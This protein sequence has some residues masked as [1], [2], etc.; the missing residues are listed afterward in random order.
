[1]KKKIFIIIGVLFTVT[2][3]FSQDFIK[4]ISNIEKVKVLD[5]HGDLNIEGVI[6]DKIQISVESQKGLPVDA[7]MARPPYFKAE[8]TGIGLSF[9]IVEGIVIIS[10][11]NQT[12]QFTNYDLK[13]PKTSQ[14][15]IKTEHLDENIEITDTKNTEIFNKINV[16]NIEAEIIIEV[17]ASKIDLSDITGPLAMA[18]FAGNCQIVFSGLN[19]DNPS[20]IE[21]FS[22]RIEVAIPENSGFNIQLGSELG[23]IYSEFDIDVKESVPSKSKNANFLNIDFKGLL[24]DEINYTGEEY[25]ASKLSGL[26]INGG[27]NLSI[28]IF[29]GNINLKKK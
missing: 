17:F 22:G 16:K 26:V 20:V 7:S 13:I 9:E 4:E 19:Q 10:P 25:T 11:A 29:A 23:E 6:D 28:N 12:A 1:M 15:E 18:V 2:N 27:I 5:I 24:S 8:N 3:S 14:V 21:M